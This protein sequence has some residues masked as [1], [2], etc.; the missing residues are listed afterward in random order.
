MFFNLIQPQNHPYYNNPS[1]NQ[2]RISA[3]TL[4]LFPLLH[5]RTGRLCANVVTVTD[6]SG[7]INTVPLVLFIRLGVTLNTFDIILNIFRLQK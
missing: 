1:D 5:C 7:V 6:I 2:R 4:P 3:Y